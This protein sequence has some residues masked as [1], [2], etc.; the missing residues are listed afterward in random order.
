MYTC[1]H[2]LNKSAWYLEGP[3]QELQGDVDCSIEHS[4]ME[5]A[6]D[7]KDEESNGRDQQPTFDTD[8]DDQYDHVTSL[9]LKDETAALENALY[10]LMYLCSAV[11]Q[12]IVSFSYDLNLVFESQPAEPDCSLYQLYSS[13]LPGPNMGHRKLSPNASENAAILAH[14]SGLYEVLF[15]VMLENELH[16]INAIQ[17]AAWNDLLSRGVNA[18]SGQIQDLRVV[19]S[20]NDEQ[21]EDTEQKEWL[22]ATSSEQ[23]ERI[24][25]TYGVRFLEL[26]RLPYWDPIWFTVLDSMHAFFLRVI[27]QHD[28]YIWGLSPTAPAGDGT[29]SPTET[30]PPRPSTMELLNGLNVLLQKSTGDACIESLSKKCHRP[31]LWHLCHAFDLRRAGTSVMLTRALLDWLQESHDNRQRAASLLQS[32]QAAEDNVDDEHVRSRLRTAKINKNI[33]NGVRV[34]T[35]RA[36]CHELGILTPD[37]K[38]CG[39]HLTKMALVDLIGKWC[40]EHGL[41]DAQGNLLEHSVDCTNVYYREKPVVLGRAILE[42]VWRDQEQL[43]LPSFIFP[44]PSLLGFEKRK[45]SANQWHSGRQWQMLNNYMHLVTAVYTASLKSTSEELAGRYTYHFKSY[46]SGILELY[47]EARVQPVHHACLHFERLLVGLGPVHSWRTWA[48]ERFNYMLQRTKT[49]M[50]FG[51]LELT[52]VND[53]CRAANLQLLL[54]SPQLPVAMKDLCNPCNQAFKSKNCGTQLDDAHTSG[55]SAGMKTVLANQRMGGRLARVHKTF[56]LLA[57]DYMHIQSPEAIRWC[58]T[59]QLGGVIFQPAA[60]SQQNSHA[61]VQL[62]GLHGDIQ[63]AAQILALFVLKGEEDIVFVVISRYMPLSDMDAE[64]DPYPQFGILAGC[65]YYDKVVVTRASHLLVPFAKTPFK[66]NSIA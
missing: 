13:I 6:S 60:W 3:A 44:A 29:N 58:E 15:L 66:L 4:I 61:M 35:L 42:E 40:I 10:N 62:P 26:L 21:N 43:V 20:G 12:Q 9:H 22:L 53:T 11:T 54:N 16:R 63:T 39:K 32:L 56:L 59:V 33:G 36:L 2:K 52:F 14:E 51:E 31:V 23:W 46:L 55:T 37:P 7:S 47:K 27:Q 25:R 41:M 19:Q 1:H 5:S 45:L 48:F 50:H 38:G 49:N 57:M 30:P 34:P 24:A 18:N 8:F 65:L 64:Q 28:R 17:Q